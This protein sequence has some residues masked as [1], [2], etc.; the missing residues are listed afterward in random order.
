MIEILLLHITLDH[1]MII[2]KETLD[3]IVHHTGHFTD[4]HTHVIHVLDA[5]L[6]LTPEIITSKNTFLHIDLFKT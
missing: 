2:I 3:H 1:V 4:H 6:D 5:N